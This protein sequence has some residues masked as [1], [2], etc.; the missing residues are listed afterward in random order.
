MSE[1]TTG[2]D[3]RRATDPL[4]LLLPAVL[5]IED[6]PNLGSMTSEMLAPDYRVDWVESAAAARKQLRSGRY[7]VLVVDRRLPDGD[8]LDLIR[9]LRGSGIAVPALVLT[10]L[11]GVDDIVE[12]LDSGANDYLT[13]PFHFV[14]LEARMRALLRGFHAQAAGVEIGDWLLKPGANLI[15]DPDG[16]AVSLTDSETKLLA[17]LAASPDHVFSRDELLSQVFSDGADAGTVDVY[18]SYVRGKT[19]RAIIDTVR[20]RGYRIGSPQE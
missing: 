2:G 7:D 15:E 5:L 19:D 6:D 3:G 10:A 20:G 16:H 1:T 9:T 12:G 8:G 18:V 13:K 11:S 4:R 17:T 14:E